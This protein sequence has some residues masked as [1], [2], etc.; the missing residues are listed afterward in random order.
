MA[1]SF[2]KFIKLSTSFYIR[3]SL[4]S[5]FLFSAVIDTE[6]FAPPAIELEAEF[7]MRLV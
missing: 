5:Y 7:F 6:S 1:L 4:E 2:Y 3:S